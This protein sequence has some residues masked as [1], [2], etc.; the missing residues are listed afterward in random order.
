[1]AQH[2]REMPKIMEFLDRYY[3]A[4]MAE[5]HLV[6]ELFLPW[7]LRAED[8]AELPLREDFVFPVLPLS[9][10][11]RSLFTAWHELSPEEWSFFYDHYYLREVDQRNQMKAMN[12]E[13]SKGPAAPDLRDWLWLKSPALRKMDSVLGV[14]L[15][16][17]D[18]GEPRLRV[19]MIN[20]VL[21]RLGLEVVN[22]SAFVRALEMKKPALL[23]LV[24]E[25]GG[26]G[27]RQFVLTAAGRAEA[28]Q[29]KE[30]FTLSKNPS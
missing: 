26:R 9:A 18:S 21:E 17:T 15:L 10:E 23:E 4:E 30:R 14:G 6:V 24:S 19:Q 13:T 3:S 2:F 5:R 1:M 25:G 28:L 22:T 16:L 29:M 11:A 8:K 7:K 12:G 20:E 27:A